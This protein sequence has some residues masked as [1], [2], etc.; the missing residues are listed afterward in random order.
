[1]FMSAGIKV[2]ALAAINRNRNQAVWA[3]SGGGIEEISLCQKRNLSARE[4]H[5]L[6]DFGRDARQAIES[7]GL[8]SKLSGRRNLYEAIVVECR[9]VSPPRAC[10][11]AWMAATLWHRPD[12][13]ISLS[14]DWYGVASTRNGD[15]A[16]HARDV[17]VVI[18]D[19]TRSNVAM[20]S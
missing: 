12:L 2:M 16:L 18:D 7:A 9:A 11:N 3:A 14:L 4:A 13:G 19:E 10:K 15:I 17:V 6:D 8:G 5:K 1:M 20:A